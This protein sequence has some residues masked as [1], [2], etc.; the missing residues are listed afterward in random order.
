M[1]NVDF[2]VRYTEV[3]EWARNAGVSVAD[4]ERRY[5]QY[6]ILHSISRNS[7]L[8]SELAFKGGNALEFVYLPN[9]STTDL[10]FSFLTGGMDSEPLRQKSEAELSTALI[11][12][13]DGFGT[14]LRL[15]SMKQNPP[16]PEAKFPTFTARVGFATPDQHRQRDRLLAGGSSAN[17][18]PVEM[19]LNE[20]VCEWRNTSIGRS[21]IDLNV[22]SI[23]DIVAEKLRAILQQTTRN[24]F[25]SQDVL[26]IASISL[27]SNL[28]IDHHKVATFLLQKSSARNVVV[29][30]ARF[31]EP[32]LRLRSAKQY[33]DLADTT[34]HTFIPFDDAWEIVMD[35]VDQL[36]IPA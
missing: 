23:N 17:V 13:N 36:D 32:E 10:D 19:T 16:R 21:N 5:C 28:Q 26:D 9:R 33:Q 30:R 15:Q 14:V 34:R 22:S 20:I 6:L 25:R 24:R 3:R 27:A 8:R 7:F 1:S 31:R 2:P 29:S 12:S 18:I 4:A 11:L 35:L